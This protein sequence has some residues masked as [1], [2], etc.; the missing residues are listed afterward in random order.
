MACGLIVITCHER[1]EPLHRS[2]TVIS[3]LAN[4]A[5]TEAKSKI[6]ALQENYQ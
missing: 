3:R 5:Y 4:T 2:D 1:T 6:G